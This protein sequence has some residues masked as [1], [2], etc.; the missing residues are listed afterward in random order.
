M[1]KFLA[2]CR[3]VALQMRISPDVLERGKASTLLAWSLPFVFRV[4]VRIFCEDKKAT[5]KSYRFPRIY[6]FNWSNSVSKDMEN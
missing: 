3:A 2:S 5:D 6:T 1:L 4:T